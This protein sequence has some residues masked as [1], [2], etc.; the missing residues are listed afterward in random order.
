ME[1][2]RTVSYCDVGLGSQ[3][4]IVE[5]VDRRPESVRGAGPEGDEKGHA[6][7]GEPGLMDGMDHEAHGSHEGDESHEGGGGDQE[8]GQQL[9]KKALVAAASASQHH[10]AQPRTES[11]ELT[12]VQLRQLESMYEHTQDPDWFTG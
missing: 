3:G 12:P 6:D 11:S 1:P 7:E 5:E 9:A 10:H 2:P 4:G 8:A